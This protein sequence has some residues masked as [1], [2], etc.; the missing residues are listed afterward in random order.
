MYG[1]L[2]FQ[3]SLSI[4]ASTGPCKSPFLKFRWPARQ[5]VEMTGLVCGWN[6][7]CLVVSCFFGSLVF[8]GCT[9]SMYEIV[10]DLSFFQLLYG[11]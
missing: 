9:I 1:F 7:F 10:E 4:Q 8:T 6:R 11:E 3:N 2:Y 5:Q